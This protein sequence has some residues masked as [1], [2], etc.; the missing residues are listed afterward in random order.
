NDNGYASLV[1][2]SAYYKVASGSEGGTPV[3]FLTPTGSTTGAAQVYRITN[4]NATIAP[5]IASLQG[6]TSSKTPDPPSLSPGWGTQD[7]LWIA[8]AGLSGSGSAYEVSYP[9]GYTNG[10]ANAYSV[11]GSAQLCAARLSNTAAAEDPGAFNLNNPS[12]WVAYTIAVAPVGVTAAPTVTGISPTSGPEAGGSSVTITGTNLSGATAVDFGT[13]AAAS[14]SV[15]SATQITAT[16]PAG[17][18]TVDITITTPGGT[19]DTDSANQFTY[20][21]DFDN[22]QP[23]ADA[24][25]PYTVDEGTSVT[26]DASGSNDPEPN[27]TDPLNYRWDFENDGT[28]D[29]GWSTSPTYSYTPCDNYVGKVAVEVSD[30][31][32]SDIA[33]AD[34]TVNNVSPTLSSVIATP[35]TINENGTTTVSG[36]ISDPSSCD[37]FTVTIDWGEGTPVD[38]SYGAGS[39]SFSETHQYLDDNPTATSSD[40]YTITVTVKDDD[41]GSDTET[42]SVTVNNVSPTLSN[43]IATP[44]N[45]DENGTTTVSGDITDPST[46]DTFTVTID[47]GEGTP[48]DYSYGAGSTSFSET[49]QYLDD[50]PTGTPS[51]IYTITVTVTDDDTGTDI[52]STSVTVNNV[53]P[54]IEVPYIAYQ[55]NPNFILPVVDNV[56]FE[57]MFSDIG[58]MDTH[59]AKWTW[60]DGSTSIGVVDESGGSGKVSGSHTFALP[61]LYR[62][63]LTVTDDDTGVHSNW[64]IVQV[65][66][67][68][69]TTRLYTL[70]NPSVYGQRATFQAIITTVPSSAVKPTGTVVFK[71]LTKGT[72]LGSVKVLSGQA[73]LTTWDLSVGSHII[74]ATYQPDVVSFK[75]SASPSV[76]QIVNKSPTTTALTSSTN[77]SM[78]GQMLTFTAT[79][80]PGA[81]GSGR[82]TGTVTFKDLT[83]RTTLGTATLNSSGMAKLSTSLRYRGTHTIVAVY[84]GNGNFNGS[85]SYNLNQRVN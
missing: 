72:T 83:A 18:G 50:N 20:V 53:P 77:P 65:V 15:D 28:W 41:D 37:T 57:G 34:I 2:F 68:A 24:N 5:A 1:R 80:R 16:S 60:G 38:Y 30:G 47:W 59:T 73:L 17:T 45:I 70:V 39:T 62:V 26:L 29:T 49:H 42:T 6:V 58:T 35:A 4:W 54:V 7:N 23:V 25:G 11:A 56:K 9:S 43:V 71:D 46:Q 48:V 76:T 44:A 81:G 14:F 82:P 67:L 40:N 79:V 19:S 21:A 51:D 3:N 78:Y 64:M 22:S 75:G 66:D 31:E 74:N 63:T 55:P 33:T 84:S 85:T 36:N 10:Y 69:T 61:G 12:N 52:D 8:T 13:S 32:L 27:P